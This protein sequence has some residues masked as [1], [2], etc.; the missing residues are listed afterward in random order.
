[1]TA[2]LRAA[3]VLLIAGD[4]TL[5]WLTACLV[6]ESLSL[7]NAFVTCLKL[8]HLAASASRPKG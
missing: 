4:A 3:V 1:M 7:D 6:E 2:A 8:S 5:Q